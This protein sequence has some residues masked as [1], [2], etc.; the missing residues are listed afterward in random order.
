MMRRSEIRRPCAGEPQSLRMDHWWLS[1]VVIEAQ[2]RNQ[3]LP[4]DVAQRVLHLHR[5]DKQ[6]VLRVDA[7]GA[8]WRLEVEAQPL[9][10]AQAAQ[11]RRTRGEVH[12]QAQIQRQR[13]C[14]NRVAA[15]EIN[16]ELHGIAEP[17]EDIDVVPTDRK[18]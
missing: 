6:I 2:V 17:A 18:S 9:L 11:A 15:Q 14:Q 13:S 10:D 3:V 1:L 5:L 12:E 16:L 4:H 8:V 7:L